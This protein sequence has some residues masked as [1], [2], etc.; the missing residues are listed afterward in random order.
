MIERR[1][2]VVGQAGSIAADRTTIVVG[3][4]I[5][6]LVVLTSALFIR[7]GISDPGSLL[8][9]GIIIVAVALAVALSI[10]RR[11]LQVVRAQLEESEAEVT[12]F[13]NS[14]PQLLWRS[15]ADGRM[16]FMNRRFT[17]ITG[18]DREEAIATQKW[19]HCIHPEDL[20]SLKES[21]D[22]S[23]QTGEDLYHVLRLRHADGEYRWMSMARRAVRSPQTGEILRWYGGST[24]VHEEVLAQ[25]KAQDLMETLEERVK[26]RTSELMRTEA[27]YAS[28]FDVSNITFAEMDFSGTA[29]ILT[30]I[31]DT[32]VSDLRAYMAEHPDELENC[33]ANV[34]TTRVNEALAKLMGYESV[35]ELTANPPA[36]NADDGPE[37]LLRQLEMVF[38][39]LEHID[40]RTVLIGKGGR[41][42]PVYYTVNRLSEGLHLSSHVDLSEQERIEDLRRAAQEELARANRIATIGAYSATIAHELN[43]PIASMRMDVATTMRW[44]GNDTPDLT[45][46]MRGLERLARTTERVANIVAHTRATVTAHRSTVTVVDLRSLAPETRD[47]MEREV[48]RA[49]ALLEMHCD[50]DVA[51]IEANPVEL[52][53]VLVNLVLNAAEAM[54]DMPGTRRIILSIQ[55][56]GDSVHFSVADS[57]P[58]IP[59]EQMDRLFEPFFTTK[60]SGMGMGLQICRNAVQNMG[61]TLKVRNRDGGGAEFSFLLPSA[62]I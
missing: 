21:L 50:T 30:A 57:G 7:N 55:N 47:L 49:G 35:V 48:K 45:A 13:A 12:T 52:Q 23:Y 10:S 16:D 43:Q 26:Q 58:G 18:V 38:Y 32:G 29:P 40:G 34:R 51:P 41:R 33:L 22:R 59:S 1:L 53:Q 44:L 42:I 56:R 31:R 2:S 9:L 54:L 14:V 4:V 39:G 11:K 28:L 20:G 5:C 8:A 15:T 19:V 6:V 37:V 60:P 61:G 27:R 24:D 62:A 3:A 46:A 17:E 25:R 36:Q